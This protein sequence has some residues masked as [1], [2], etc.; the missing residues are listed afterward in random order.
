MSIQ[1]QP[2]PYYCEENIWKLAKELD[3][4]AQSGQVVF[5]SNSE[6][7]CALW[8]QKASDRGDGLVLWDYHVVFHVDGLLWDLDS[9]LGFPLLPEDWFAA[10]FPHGDEIPPRFLP[11][12]RLVAWPEFERT[13]SS[14]RSHMRAPDGGWQAPPPPWP[15]I[16]GDK[17]S[18]LMQFVDFKA[19]CPGTVMTL[20]E[21]RL[22]WALSGA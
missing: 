4:R 21:V 11:Q 8:D 12:F 16:G 13:F 6:R 20:S 22:A 9:R 17:A 7:V 5:V 1:F 10:T 19:P 2:T 18:N 14:D 3:E 15:C